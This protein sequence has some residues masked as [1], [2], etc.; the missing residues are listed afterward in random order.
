[1]NPLIQF[2]LRDSNRSGPVEQWTHR[3]LFGLFLVLWILALGRQLPGLGWLSDARWAEA[4]WLAAAAFLTVSSLA[5]QI[6]LQNAL[7]AAGVIGLVGGAAHWSS[8]VTQ[9]PFGPL[10]FPHAVGLSPFQEWFFVPVLIW[11][12]LLLNARGLA[13]LIL[14]PVAKHPN[15]G[16]HLLCLSTCLM[17]AAALAL[18]PFASAVHRY[19]L[20]GQT[21]LPVTWL[22]VP[23]SG[24]LAWTVVSVIASLAATP[25]LID[26][27][28]RPAPPDR[29]P[30]W[31]WAL[32]NGLF[33]VGTAVHGLW[34]AVVVATLSAVAATTLGLVDWRRNARGKPARQH[35][36]GH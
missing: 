3:G 12:V 23:L 34:P 30:A 1:V 36:S 18:E 26:K 10:R 28:P 25:F 15:R 5:R 35:P 19:W 11:V 6:S 31:I 4:A 16:L 2:T 20:W 9:I 17:L 21:R 27:H 13:R 29:G 32:L 14:R 7:M 24:L 8:L 22:G 33:A